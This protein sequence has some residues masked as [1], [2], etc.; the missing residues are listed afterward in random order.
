[1]KN[2]IQNNAYVSYNDRNFNEASLNIRDDQVYV[3][4]YPAFC[5]YMMV[6]F[7]MNKNSWAI[8]F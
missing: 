3:F 8:T 2:K 6:S 7:K 5:N 1:M 4:F